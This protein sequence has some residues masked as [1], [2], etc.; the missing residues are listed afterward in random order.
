[1]SHREQAVI[2]PAELRQKLLDNEELALIDV[3]EIRPH[4]HGHLL[5][6]IP[7]P[8]P[9]VEQRVA[10]LIPCRSALVVVCDGGEPDV[11]NPELGNRAARR[12]AELGYSN[13]KVLEGGTAGWEAAG[14][15]LFDGVNVPSKAFG[16]F[17]EE[18]EG[19]PS[20]TP[21]ALKQMQDEGAD[22]VLLDSRPEEEFRMLSLPG[23]VCCPGGELA[24]RVHEIVSSPDTTVV[25]N[26]AGRTRSI[27]GCQS[28]I[29]A[30]IPNKVLALRNGVM[31][32]HLAGQQVLHGESEMAPAPGPQAMARA[33]ASADALAQRFVVQTV[34]LDTLNIW[35][36][37]RDV[38]SLY[39]LDV[40]T[41][42]EFEQQRLPDAVHA[43]GGQL[44]QNTDLYVATRNARLVLVDSEQVR[45]VFAASWLQQMGKENVYVLEQGWQGAE[46]TSGEREQN[47]LGL[48]QVDC[49]FVQPQELHTM[50]SQDS[51]QVLDVSLSDAYEKAHID[52][53]WFVPRARLATAL[54]NIPDSGTYVLTSDDGIVAQLA[55]AELQALSESRVMVLAGGNRAWQ[56][57]GL[58][59]QTGA[60]NK[61][62][63]PDDMWQIPFLPDP[64]TGKSAEDNMREYLSWEVELV[65]QIERDGT[66]NFKRYPH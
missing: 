21:E 65:R 35:R 3:R 66:T 36:A 55:A 31:G 64:D 23:G 24:Y 10:D 16:E 46:T 9:R 44:V 39:V 29:N 40:R 32:W 30:A 6:A 1:M 25:V 13:V 27:I 37:E 57:S 43:P 48:E 15:E 60:G 2:T 18:H 33:R 28:L 41:G 62:L 34:S 11:D 59:M 38:R 12:L 52:G 4:S 7:L 53:A 20:I 14:Y 26:C 54:E 45:A 51:L 17:V 47:I 61:S 22:M 42:E 63:K 19:T 5:F 8:L 50:M 49:S 56:Q 58:P